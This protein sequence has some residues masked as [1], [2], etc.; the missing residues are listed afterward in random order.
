MV[1]CYE[2]QES[3]ILVWKVCFFHSVKYKPF[4][5]ADLDLQSQTKEKGGK[6][7]IM[8]VGNEFGLRSAGLGREALAFFHFMDFCHLNC[9]VQ[10]KQR[11]IKSC[12]LFSYSKF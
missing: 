11:D 10:G 4:S 2:Q 8:V 1:L 6:I 7:S 3:S 5:L 12:I 9:K